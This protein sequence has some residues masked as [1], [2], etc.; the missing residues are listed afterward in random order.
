MIYL[1]ISLIPRAFEEPQIIFQPARDCFE[2]ELAN[3]P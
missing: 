3:P 2:D 1:P